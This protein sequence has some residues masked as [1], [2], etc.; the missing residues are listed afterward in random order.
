MT[1][2]STHRPTMPSQGTMM[3]RMTTNPTLAA[4]SGVLLVLPFVTLNSIVGNRIEPFFSFIRPGIHTSS[5]EYVLLFIVLLLIPLGAFLTARPLLQKGADGKRRF[6]A[7]NAILATLLCI[8]FV[9]LSVGLG[10]DIYRC[11]IL[12]IPNCD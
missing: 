11:D 8:V 10:S 2:P 3:T 4:L 7:V 12:R 5:L 1:G 9:M 6:Y